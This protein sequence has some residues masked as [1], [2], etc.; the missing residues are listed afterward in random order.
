MSQLWK[1]WIFL[2]V[3][4]WKIGIKLATIYYQRKE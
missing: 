3:V 1:G 2:L 4:I